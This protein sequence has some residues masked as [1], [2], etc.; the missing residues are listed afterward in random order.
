MGIASNL[1]TH[2]P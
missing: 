1:V 2:R